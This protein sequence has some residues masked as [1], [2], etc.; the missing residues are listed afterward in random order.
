MDLLTQHDTV[1]SYVRSVGV[2]VVQMKEA[3][4]LVE[5][6]LVQNRIN[7]DSVECFSQLSQSANQKHT[8]LNQEKEV[9]FVHYLTSLA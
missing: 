3:L 7:V 2:G 6:G 8:Y 1:Y 5:D 9:G 4:A